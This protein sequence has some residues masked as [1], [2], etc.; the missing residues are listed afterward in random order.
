MK[1]TSD[2][3]DELEP[4]VTD[5][6][7]PV[8]LS[9]QP[10]SPVK[11]RKPVQ[12]SPPKEELRN[13]PYCSQSPTI[14]EFDRFVA[15]TSSLDHKPVTIAVPTVSITTIS[16][17]P[18]QFSGPAVSKTE[19]KQEKPYKEVF[20]C[21]KCLNMVFYLFTPG[22]TCGRCQDSRK[23]IIVCGRCREIRCVDCSIL[24]N[25]YRGA[26]PPVQT[27]S[28]IK[29]DTTQ[30]FSTC[31]FCPT[32]KFMS[33]STRGHWT[34]KMHSVNLQRSETPFKYCSLRCSSRKNAAPYV[35]KSVLVNG[36]TG[37][38]MED[39]PDSVCAF[40]GGLVFKKYENPPK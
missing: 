19:Q 13:L 2:F 3:F 21:E 27:T 39:E 35:S 22:E 8:K 34:T 9:S 29:L 38:S 4:I 32:A 16:A 30:S 5:W 24:D 33:A 12:Q 31:P 17:P 37:I 7:L 36:L 40:C 1:Q 11:K 20:R 25:L 14:E 18:L 28:N 23:N 6:F 26:A 15:A 10:T